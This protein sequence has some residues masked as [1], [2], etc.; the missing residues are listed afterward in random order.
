[1]KVLVIEDDQD[2]VQLIS[3]CI[4]LRR[5]QTEVIGAGTGAKGLELTEKEGP[6]LIVLDI[7]LPDIDGREL[8]DRIRMFSDVPVIMLTGRD[9]DADIASALEKGADDYV[10][11]PF[12]YIEFLARIQAV[13]RRAHGR[14]D[15]VNPPL[16]AGDLV[17]DFDAADVHRGGERVHL[18]L[19]ERK[20]LEYL[21]RNS[22][23]V[24]TYET[25]ASRVLDVEDPGMAESRLIRVHVQH[26]RA[27]LG[28]P[29]DR[30]TLISNVR[31]VGYR[32]LLSVTP[33]ADTLD[34]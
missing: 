4:K 1:M 15:S 31:G 34:R 29:A 13:L 25:L 14:T 22:R 26:L 32:F 3:T 16:V 2:T 10:T 20:I 18:T 9:R 12:S 33:L 11:K 17:M 27:K 7:G 28:D 8:L 19:S 6:D 23:R 24:V 21:V 5:P 30:P